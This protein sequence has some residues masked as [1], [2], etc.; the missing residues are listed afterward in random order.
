MLSQLLQDSVEGGISVGL[1][2]PKEAAQFEGILSGSNL[3]P[4]VRDSKNQQKP[5]RLLSSLISYE[6]VLFESSQ[7]P[8]LIAE[9]SVD[10]RILKFGS[11]SQVDILECMLRYNSE[12]RK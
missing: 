5:Y 10:V 1:S 12:C 11:H 9:S 3:K 6:I 7:V 2:L 8:L 4:K